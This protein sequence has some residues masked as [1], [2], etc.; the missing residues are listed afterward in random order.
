[1]FGLEQIK[2]MNKDKKQYWWDRMSD[3]EKA[4]HPSLNPAPD[5]EPE[6]QNKRRG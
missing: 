3:A 6:K 5:P 1:M 4:E 2:T